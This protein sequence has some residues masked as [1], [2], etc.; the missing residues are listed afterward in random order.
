MRPQAARLTFRSPARP[1]LEMSD[2][3]THDSITPTP[4]S[5]VSMFQTNSLA[6]KASAAIAATRLNDSAVVLLEG[7]DWA[8]A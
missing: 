6:M 1:R 7:I 5:L 8:G 4:T 2:A 3:P